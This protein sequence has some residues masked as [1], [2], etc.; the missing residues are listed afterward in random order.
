VA[1]EQ[2][3]KILEEIRDLQKAHLESYRQAVSNQD[4]AIKLQKASVRRAKIIQT[5][6]LIF[7]I[8]AL[9]LWALSTHR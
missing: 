7:M 3:I 5:I 2:V 1:E 8:G 4:E 6:F 9:M